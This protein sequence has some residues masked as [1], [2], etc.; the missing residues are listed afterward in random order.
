[1]KKLED[2]LKGFVV[3]LGAIVPG[4]SGGVLAVMLKVY[5]RIIFG[6]SNLR[7]EFWKSVKDLLP[8]GV[9]AVVSIAV[10]W[11]PLN[12]AFEY[13]PFVIVSLFAGLILGSMPTVFDEVKGSK[14]KPIHI[15]I[16]I[17]SLAVAIGIGV[18][19]VQFELDMGELFASLPWWLYLLMIPLGVLIAITLI[20][21]GISGSML[22]IAMGFYKHLLNLAQN[23]ISFINVPQSIGLLLCLLVGIIV[24]FLSLTKLMN[25]VLL[26]HKTGIYSLIIGFVIGSF[27]SLYYNNDM[28]VCY[29]AGIEIWQY[30]L[31]GVLLLAGTA[32][33]YWFVL[34]ERKHT[35]NMSKKEEENA[36]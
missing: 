8:L 36:N 29:R 12:L 2:V 28:M 16:F 4:V 30:I 27:V 1:M 5:D 34:F 9:G 3:G 20:V 11:Y 22:L 26:H 33:S 7:K 35:K 10:C 31:G 17:V 18:F 21:P 19:S 13:I 23:I 24:G 14:I 25:Y 6:I 15:V 32:F